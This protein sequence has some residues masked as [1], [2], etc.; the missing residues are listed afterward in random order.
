MDFE[1]NGIKISVPAE[2]QTDE[3][4]LAAILEL[5]KV[6]QNRGLELS[7]AV[8]GVAL[9]A[10]EHDNVAAS[11]LLSDT[12]EALLEQLGTT[13]DG[14]NAVINTLNEGRRAK[15]NRIE[16]ASSDELAAEFS[17][18]LTQEDIAY[19]AATQEKDPEV[20]F[21]VV[22]TPNVLVD[23]KEVAKAG[24]AFGKDQPYNTYVDDS[25]YA[26]YSAEQLSGTNPGNGNKVQFSL[27]SS[28]FTPELE[29]TV[30][31]QQAGLIEL[32]AKNPDVYLKV[33]SILEDITY[34]QTLRAADHKLTGNGTFNL[35]YNRKFDLPALPLDDWSCVPRS[36]VDDRGKPSVDGSS[37][38]DRRDG[39]VS[40]SV[41]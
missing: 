5:A 21:T 36:C 34:C 2:T 10:S 38:D 26:G 41:G 39:R 24:R 32:Q 16:L 12:K 22:A 30:P 11:E 17:G 20:T 7:P 28:K 31:E 4:V 9:A 27:F 25:F 14:Y 19:V 3:L 23:S 33:S 6:A 40:V 35:T 37:V 1:S 18:R 13:Y 15:K 29:G 8:G